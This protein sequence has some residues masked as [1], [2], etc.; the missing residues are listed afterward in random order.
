MSRRKPLRPDEPGPPDSPF[1]FAQGK[2]GRLSPHE[3]WCYPHRGCGA[4][5]KMHRSF[6][7]AKGAL[8]QDDNF[9]R[10]DMVA[11][12]TEGIIIRRL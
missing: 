10:R 8:L 7:R 11:V 6:S 5:G 2:L 4:G 3:L 9:E 1:G 12:P